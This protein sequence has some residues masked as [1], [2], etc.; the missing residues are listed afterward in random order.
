MLVLMACSKKNEGFVIPPT[1][2][3]EA[4]AGVDVQDFM[5]KV[6]NYWY[7]WQDEV[8]DLADDRFPISEQG[9]A[10]YTAFLKS[11]AN[12]ADFFT[13]KLRFSEDRF[14]FFSDDYTTLT[15]SLAGISKSNGLEFG[16]INF[17]GSETVFG[18]VR[19]IFHRRKWSGTYHN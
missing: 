16:L 1:V 15:N 10:D 7:F 9:T 3:A 13:N 2:E 8:P 18:L 4:N 12:P 5:W 6:M 11:E 19:Y 14:S 17:T